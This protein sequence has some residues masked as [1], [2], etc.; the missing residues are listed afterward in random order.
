MEYCYS[1]NQNRKLKC[2]S[3]TKIATPEEEEE[4]E[5]QLKFESP[6]VVSVFLES[7]LMLKAFL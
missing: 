6:N 4:E 2:W 7:D 1:D 3:V 5:K